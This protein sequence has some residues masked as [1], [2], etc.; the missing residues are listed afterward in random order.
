MMAKEMRK[1]S[2]ESRENNNEFQKQWEEMKNKIK[3]YA[4]DGKNECTLVY[5]KHNED[6]IQK[7]KE[8]GF[9]VARSYEIHSGIYYGMRNSMTHY[10]VW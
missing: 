4:S 7:L 8:N 6:L 10:V 2:Q 1:L 9:K 5:G 3:K